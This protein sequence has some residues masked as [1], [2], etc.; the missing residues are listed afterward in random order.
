VK[1]TQKQM[2]RQMSQ[3][4]TDDLIKM[5]ESIEVIQKKAEKKERKARAKKRAKISQRHAER[6]LAEQNAERRAALAALYDD[7]VEEFPY[8]Y[9][10]NVHL[11]GDEYCTLRDGHEGEHLDED[12][13]A[14]ESMGRYEGLGWPVEDAPDDYTRVALELSVGKIFADR[15]AGQPWDTSMPLPKLSD[16]LTDEDVAYLEKS[17]PDFD[18]SAVIEQMDEA[19]A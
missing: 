19:D 1:K 9:L 13:I 15:F 11:E 16:V 18:V 7:P 14:L 3:V 10:C 5:I 12:S 6:S 17:Y 2:I 4:I 8:R